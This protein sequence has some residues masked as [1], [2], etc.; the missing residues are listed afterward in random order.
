MGRQEF[1]QS[2]D[3]AVVDVETTGLSPAFGDRVC[4]IAIV[5]L[6]GGKE[7]TTFETFINPG[8]PISPGAAAVNGITAEM[9]AN[10]PSFQDAAPEI[11]K[12][13]QSC[14]FVAHNAP[15]DLGFLLAEFQRLRLPLPVSQV[16]DTLAIARRYYTFPSNSL[17]VIADQLNIPYPQ[18]HRA[19]QDARVTGQILHV[20]V[21]DLF[22]RGDVTAEELVVPLAA[23]LLPTSDESV[24][25]PPILHE[26]LTNGLSL[27]IR[28]MSAGMDL[29]VRQVDPLAI[30]P[31]RD[32]LYLRAY[33]HL[34]QDERT[35][36]L[37]RIV[38]MRIVGKRKGGSCDA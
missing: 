16:V 7:I 9:V 14:V 12:W 34:R 26:A 23:V 19:L 33:C 24:I 13:I 11:S 25:L 37:D 15:F 10:A 6:R 3:F 4:E 22:R 38:E 27:E 36:R 20:F 2:V 29:S 28:Y 8:R 21:R 31:N 18:R 17:G 30:V 1:L 32:Y 5:R 35:F